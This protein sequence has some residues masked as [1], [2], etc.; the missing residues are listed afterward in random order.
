MKTFIRISVFVAISIFFSANVLFGQSKITLN[1]LGL[2]TFYNSMT[3]A[4]AAAANGDTL[5]LPGGTIQPSSDI[6]VNKSV[7][8]VGAGHYPDS[9]AATGRTEI[10]VLR[11]LTGSSNSSLQ[12]CS[13][14]SL[15]IGYATNQNITG[16]SVTRCSMGSFRL[17]NDAISTINNIFLADNVFNGT[18]I[19]N[20][21]Y[22]G[23]ILTRN[24]MYSSS[25][26]AQYGGGNGLLISNNIIYVYYGNAFPNYHNCNFENNL[27]VCTSSASSIQIKSSNCNYTNNLFIPTVSSWGS[28]TEQNS[29][30]NQTLTNTFENAGNSGFSYNSN[31]NLKSSS[32]GKNYG[33]DGTD[34]GIYGTIS[35]YKEGAVPFNPHIRFKSISSE[36]TPEGIL[37][38]NI[39]VS[40]QDR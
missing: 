9:S 6:I 21:A 36:T 23:V 3:D 35:P 27:I 24:F 38:V 1:H 29:L 17:G 25:S 22:S 33:T 12:G 11:F 39:S 37:N 30:L 10:N 34:V 28:N 26:G 19:I 15:Y 4:L 2:P 31:Y 40:A 16:I 7:H 18:H 8:I 20:S 5:Y 13:V 14:E 32:P